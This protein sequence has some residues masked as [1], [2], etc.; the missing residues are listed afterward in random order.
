MKVV[1]Y[2]LAYNLYHRVSLCDDHAARTAGLGPVSHGKH[3]GMCDRC[4]DD[5][6]D[7]G[8]CPK[9]GD[10]AGSES[11]DHDCPFVACDDPSC[12]AL[13]DPP[14]DVKALRA[15][16][17]HWRTHSRYHGCSHGN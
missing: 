15:A 10:P 2:Q 11:F 3:E 8:P 4:P 17:E 9:C 7:D 6:P 5:G 13:K 14:D 1:T 16:Y 12:R